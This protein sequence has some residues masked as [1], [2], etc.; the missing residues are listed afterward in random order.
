MKVINYRIELL[1]PALVTSVQ[2]DPNSAV[3]FDYL[4]GSV[5][6]GI[7]I[8]KYL[9]SKSADASD[10][11]L[12]RLFF[13]GTTR[14]LN[15][16]P[17]DA[18]DQD[19]P[20]IPVPLSWYQDKGDTEGKIFDFAIKEGND[21]LQW[22]PVKEPFYAQPGQS[23]RLI[24]PDRNVAVHTQ[25]TA[26]FGRAMS[27]YTDPSQTGGKPRELVKGDEI[28]GAVYRYDALAAG[29]TFEAAIL[30]DNDADEQTLRGLLKDLMG[31]HITLGGSRSGGYGQAKIT[32]ISEEEVARDITEKEDEEEIG[33]S[34][35]D[36]ADP[37]TTEDEKESQDITEGVE[38]EEQDIDEDVEEEE[39]D[40]DED[41]EEEDQDIDEDGEDGAKD[42]LIVTL[43]SDVLLRDKRGQFAVDPELLRQ[44]LGRHLQV[45]DEHQEVKLKLEDAFLGTQVIGGF[46]RKWGLPLPQAL[47]VS[48]GS[49]L[50]FK[51]PGCDP[52]LLE[53]LEARGIGERRAE[54]FGRIAFNRQHA[55]RL[56][57]EKIT[58][59]KPGRV[60]FIIGQTE[61]RD[62]AQLMVERMLRKRLDER[63]LAAA[64]RVEIAN[65]PSNAQLSRL[66]G[67][68]LEELRK[69]TPDIGNI[70]RFIKGISERGSARRQFER[71][72]LD[73]N[74]P[75]LRWLK[76]LL[77]Y[78]I[79]G[80]WTMDDDEWK[81][82][83]RMNMVE[84]AAQIG[85]VEAKIDDSLRLEYVLRL[86]NLVLA[87]AAKE[88]GKGN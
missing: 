21:K 22:Q 77:R 46:N 7:L 79:D 25:R 4:P 84:V 47:A 1:E 28:P 29:Q 6:R 66:R 5:L 59:E 88:R 19:Q 56:E 64:N 43:Q 38:E 35:D 78:D 76:C 69:A 83:L 26:R 85:D 8:G 10:D 9:A 11:T 63:L 18:E 62:L 60:D 42:K 71:S 81:D 72:I 12:R 67:V 70:H 82:L 75:L 40:I 80:P 61:A 86:I 51:D 23:V 74:E 50:V 52:T 30:C 33:R 17:L 2:G 49:V 37:D 55:A 14:Y 65:P 31:G 36:E 54:G 3:A 39:Q 13:N 87:K 20:S 34:P 58:H 73:G 15:G 68:V 57:V 16:Y 44:V 32:W 53:D 48:M 45:L 41:V 24:S 27:K